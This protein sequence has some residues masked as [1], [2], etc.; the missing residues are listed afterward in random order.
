MSQ[1]I[2][3]K[4]VCIA[5][6]LISVLLQS[7]ESLPQPYFV[8]SGISTGGKTEKNHFNNN[9]NVCLISACTH[10]HTPTHTEREK[11]R[12]RENPILTTPSCCSCTT[13]AH[14]TSGVPSATGTSCRLLPPSLPCLLV[15]QGE[16]GV[17]WNSKL[18][19]Y[20]VSTLDFPHWRAG[21]PTAWQDRH[22][23]TLLQHAARVDCST[24]LPLVYLGDL[25]TIWEGGSRLE[26]EINYR[27]SGYCQYCL[28]PGHHP[29]LSS[30][31]WRKCW[32]QWYSSVLKRKLSWST[33][34]VRGEWTGSQPNPVQKPTAWWL[35]LGAILRGGVKRQLSACPK[36]Q[37]M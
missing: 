29:S 4:L 13:T 9:K 1:Q 10:T 22:N 36:S 21:L 12:E 23:D 30:P 7:S 25:A 33:E 8:K 6:F 32:D 31:L 14:T 18:P 16:A 17:T 2:R 37:A 27:Q 5:V 20:W 11:E 24:T 34:N 35:V 28:L 3:L 26:S 15:P 19:V